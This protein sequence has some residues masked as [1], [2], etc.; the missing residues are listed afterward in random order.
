[1]S[2]SHN[3]LTINNPNNVGYHVSATMPI[4]EWVDAPVDELTE[5]DESVANVQVKDLHL[6]NFWARKSEG[7]FKHNALFNNINAMGLDCIGSCFFPKAEIS[8]TINSQLVGQSFNRTQGFKFDPQNEFKHH[9]KANTPFHIIHFAVS[10]TYIFDFL[11]TNEAWADHLRTRI[12]KGERIINSHYPN[13]TLAQE[14]ILQNIMDCPLMGK[15]RVMMMETSIVQLMLL[16]FHSHYQNDTAQHSAANKKEVD[17]VYG[18][19]DYL[20]NNF[21]QDHSLLCIAKHFG[22]NTNKLMTAFKKTFGKS[23]FEYISE[24]K[25]ELAHRMLQDE[26]KQVVEV[27]R[28]TGYKNPNHF[29][30]A[31]KKR[32]GVC[33]SQVG[34]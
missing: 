33:P 17:L 5:M 28:V 26:G 4:A 19:K 32:F 20:T 13:I 8:T 11:P 30:T 9:L 27:A 21:L 1:M 22:T 15:F 29:S 6:P 12:H 34:L 24:L 14:R 31:F 23:V 2:Q 16:Q 18:V 3:Y 25:M 10:P 7:V